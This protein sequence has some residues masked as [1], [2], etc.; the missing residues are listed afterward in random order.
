M[1]INFLIVKMGKENF[2]FEKCP[3]TKTKMFKE[4]TIFC[5]KCVILTS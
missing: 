5:E 1:I 2:M 3:K 4:F